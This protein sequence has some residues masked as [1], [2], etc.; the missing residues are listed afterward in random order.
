MGFVKGEQGNSNRKKINWLTLGYFRLP[1][2]K[3][4]AEG[5][6]YYTDS[7][8]LESPIFRK[9]NWSVLGSICFLKVAV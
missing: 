2:C 6:P 5:L 3:G 4:E 8:G 9:N 1:F 7:G